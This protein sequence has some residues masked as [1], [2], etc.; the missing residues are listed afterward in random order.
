MCKAVNFVRKDDLNFVENLGGTRE[1][2]VRHETTD[3]KEILYV[4]EEFAD[5]LK[6]TIARHMIDTGE[7]TQEEA[8]DYLINGMSEDDEPIQ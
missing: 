7:W 1:D 4:S 3:D 2:I 6:K 8:N 5:H